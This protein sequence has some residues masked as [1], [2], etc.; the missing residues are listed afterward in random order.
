VPLTIKEEIESL[1]S[2]VSSNN[3]HLVAILEAID[4]KLL[5]I[6]NKMILMENNGVH[7]GEADKN[8]IAR[9]VMEYEI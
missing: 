7:I 4:L 8:A 6:E 9:A 3:T 1:K 2:Q 5:S